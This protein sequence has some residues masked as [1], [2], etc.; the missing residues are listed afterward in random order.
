MNRRS[1][2]MLL[3]SLTLLAGGLAIWQ[4]AGVGVHPDPEG[5]SSGISGGV[6]SASPG[7]QAKPAD[8][9]GVDADEVAVEVVPLA[10]VVGPVRSLVT[11]WRGQRRLDAGIQMLG[12]AAVERRELGVRRMP[13]PFGVAEP[14]VALVR[15]QCE[16]RSLHRRV[17]LVQPEV[18][19]ELQFG[20]ELEVTGQVFAGDGRPL[21]GCRVWAGGAVEQEVVTDAD[22]RY[23]IPVVASIGVPLVVRA[24]GF[25]A[26]FRFVDVEAGSANAVDFRLEPEC[27][28]RVQAAATVGGDDPLAGAEVYVA[29]AGEVST[30]L[31][32][33]PFFLQGLLE[34]WELD[35]RGGVVVRGLPRGVRVDVGVR[36]PRIGRFTKPSVEL[37]GDRK[38]VTVMLVQPAEQLR[39]RIVDET[40]DPVA[41]VVIAHTRS[42]VSAAAADR[43][44]LPAAVGSAFDVVSVTGSDG[45]FVLA[46]PARDDERIQI[47]HRNVGLEWRAGWRELPAELALPAW[48]GSETALRLPAG[49]GLCWAVGNLNGEDGMP[50]RPAGPHKAV[51]PLPQPMLAVLA[52]RRRTADGGWSE[53][54]RTAPIYVR[55]A[56]ELPSDVLPR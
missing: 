49:S 16:G 5:L 44:L 2:T 41:G 20:P 31:L 34:R 39:G 48:K 7:Q 26:G 10:L 21:A 54:Q 40:G 33:Y 52:I 12:G 18:D 47:A 8:P 45:Q 55:G 30:S 38:D 28:L 42:A 53:P 6:G 29:P 25:A 36:G 9:S 15:I 19:I 3:A 32:Q 22:G 14:G 43:W 13:W 23:R 56:F 51:L 1:T 17:R 46:A 11:V 37:R 4:L 27:V 24:E 50:L 35:E